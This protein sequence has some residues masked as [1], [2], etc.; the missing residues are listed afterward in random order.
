MAEQ[1][2]QDKNRHDPANKPDPTTSDVSE[3]TVVVMHRKHTLVALTAA[4]A[5]LIILGGGGY[6]GYT[7]LHKTAPKP[8]AIT[9]TP[10]PTPPPEPPKPTTKASPLTGVQIDPALADRPI[11][12]VVIENHTDA[13]PQSG[14]SQAGVVYEALAEGGITRFLAFF[15]DERPAVLGPVR[16]IRTYFVD[17]ALEFNAPV[18]HAGG[19]VDA[20]D[21]IAPLHMKDMNQFSFG[22]YFYRSNDRFAPHNLYST[23]DLLDKLEQALGFATPSNFVPSPRKADAPA[24]N[25]TA[26]DIKIN[27]SY[28]GYQVEYK[29]DASSNSYARFLAGVPHVDR[30]TGKQIMVKN[31]VVEYMPTS[32]G[33]TRF[34]EQTVMM[35]TPG[36]GQ[37]IVFRDGVA[38]TGTWTKPNHTTRTRLLDAAGK[39]IPLDAGNT[40]YSIVPVGRT[41]QY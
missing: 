30:N 25:A 23:S 41:I 5:I 24:A 39:D 18:A 32:Y 20:L 2:V 4:V 11:T 26:A 28:N 31:M 21:L 33:T 27:Y 7:L 6:L 12:A 35:G 17:W 1:E 3:G 16:S 9:P 14:L 8:A 10:K 22:N 13:R 19:N 37:A 36:S 34:G 29:Y 38:I 40:W 15:L